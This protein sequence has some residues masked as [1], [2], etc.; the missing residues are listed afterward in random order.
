MHPTANEIDN[1]LY[2]TREKKCNC[3][4]PIKHIK[5]LLYN[6]ISFSS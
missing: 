5:S 3:S 1:Y 4:T 2:S 6:I